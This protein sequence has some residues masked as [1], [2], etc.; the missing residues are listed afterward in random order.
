MSMNI[1]K[2]MVTKMIEK[3]LKNLKVGDRIRI[4]GTLFTIKR[5][6]THKATEEHH[7]DITSFDLGNG[8][9]FGYDWKWSFVQKVIKNGFLGFTSTTSRPIEI[10]SIEVLKNKNK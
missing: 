10:K 2:N 6:E 5:G 4:N 8:F 1:L 3:Q 9:A 7:S